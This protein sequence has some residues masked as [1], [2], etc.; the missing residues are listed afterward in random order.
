M[1]TTFF[2]T[3]RRMAASPGG[4][5]EHVG[6]VLL[7]GGTVLSR[8]DVFDWMRSGSLFSTRAP[9]GSEARVIRVH[10]SVC[11]DDYLRTDRDSSR[12]DNLNALPTF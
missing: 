4:T 5:H 6:W 7:S 8:N 2:I 9:D 3:H 1:A 11:S 12:S 10:C